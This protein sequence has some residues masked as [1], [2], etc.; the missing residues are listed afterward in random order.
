MLK[1]IFKHLYRILGIEQELLLG[2]Q[3]SQYKL[4]LLAG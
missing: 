3:S 4:W 2:F 1:L